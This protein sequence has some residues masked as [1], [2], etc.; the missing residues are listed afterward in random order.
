MPNNQKFRKY[1][2]VVN[3]RKFITS[4][5]TGM[6]LSNVISRAVRYYLKNFRGNYDYGRRNNIELK[7]KW[8]LANKDD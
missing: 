8:R 1:V 3:E 4:A 6:F 5:G 2:F 7:I